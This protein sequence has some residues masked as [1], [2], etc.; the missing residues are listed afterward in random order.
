[1]FTVLVLENSRVMDQL[2]KWKADFIM[3]KEAACGI[4]ALACSIKMAQMHREEQPGSTFNIDHVERYLHR[5]ITSLSTEEVQPHLLDAL[6]EQEVAVELASLSDY[7][8][9]RSRFKE[10]SVLHAY[11]FANPVVATLGDVLAHQREE[12]KEAVVESAVKETSLPD[13]QKID[14]EEDDEIDPDFFDAGLLTAAIKV[15][16]AIE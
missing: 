6:R 15:I 12:T 9:E 3:A 11:L 2:M 8:L 4:I 7:F 5:A 10:F 13:T 1:M 16:D 14:E